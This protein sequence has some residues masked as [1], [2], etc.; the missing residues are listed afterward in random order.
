MAKDP[1]RPVRRP[2]RILLVLLSVLIIPF[3]VVLALLSTVASPFMGL[4]NILTVTPSGPELEAAQVASRDM[5]QEV[6]SEA[7]VLL[8]NDGALPL[9][10]GT[11]VNVFG[12]GSEQ[13]VYGGTGSGSAD[14]SKNV[15]LL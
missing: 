6:E 8:E 12:V 11:K 4:L 9:G 5:T 7:I 3:L 13:F 2:S 1:N 15:T 14:E 10:T